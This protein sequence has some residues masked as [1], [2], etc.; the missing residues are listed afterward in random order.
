M[1]DVQATFVK[2]LDHFF[3]AGYYLAGNE[4][5]FQTPIGYHYANRPTKSVDR[6]REVVFTNFDISAYPIP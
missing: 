6:V 5:S 3:D 4:P 2:R 1:S